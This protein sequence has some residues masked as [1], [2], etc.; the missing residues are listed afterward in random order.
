MTSPDIRD[1]AA[2]IDDRITAIEVRR[3]A[4]VAG[5]VRRCEV[6]IHTAI[7]TNVFEACRRRCLKSG[8]GESLVEDIRLQ[9]GPATHIQQKVRPEDMGISSA[10]VGMVVGDI[11]SKVPAIGDLSW[12][13]IKLTRPNPKFFS[14]LL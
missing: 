11:Y 4:A 13:Y 12:T 14:L 3:A 9:H 1:A 8:G 7:L 10:E 6:D 5:G 2:A